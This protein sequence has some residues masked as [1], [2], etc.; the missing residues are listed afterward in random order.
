MEPVLPVGLPP[1]EAVAYFERKGY[2]FSF[3]WRDIERAEHAKA[4]T[5]AK[6]MRADILRDL[7]GAV[8]QAI[9]QGT[10][11]A[12]FERELTPTLQ[13]KGWWGK[14]LLVDP[15]DGV[16]KLVQLGS[17]RRLATIYDT[18]VRTSYAAGRW[19]QIQR[20]KARRPYLRYI[21][22]DNAHP[23]PQHQAWH[24]LVLPIDDPFWATHY[25]PNGWRCHC[26]VQQLSDRDLERYGYALAEAPP[27]RTSSY[28]NRRTG[29]TREVPVGIDPGFDY[30]P[31]IAGLAHLRALEGV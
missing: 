3:S 8:D 7:Q 14:Q 6:V 20:T 19:E 29:E 27:I 11:L 15:Q 31:G 4:F 12:A 30:N 5:V 25:P 1:A 16:E 28:T 23:R 18:N 2:R 17:P 21:H 13:A 22:L 9:A 10:T 24:G 26:A